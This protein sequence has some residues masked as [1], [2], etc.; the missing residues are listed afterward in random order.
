MGVGLRGIAERERA[1][2]G[3]QGQFRRVLE[4]GDEGE[5]RRLVDGGHQMM[6][7]LISEAV[8]DAQRVHNP[9]IEL[10]LPPHHPHL[11]GPLSLSLPLKLLPTIH[12]HYKPIN[13]HAR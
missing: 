10:V 2:E 12:K 1:V 7:Q 11:A 8:L 4:A 3:E 5:Q 9:Q 6:Q 13:H